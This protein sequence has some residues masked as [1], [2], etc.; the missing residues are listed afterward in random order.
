MELVFLLVWKARQ[1][2]EFQK[3][4][5]TLQGLLSQKGASSKEI[6][7]AFEALK[8]A[9]FPYEKNQTKEENRQMRE[10]LE[11]EVKRGPV[12]V[13]PLPELTRPKKSL[14]QEQQL[15]R[16]RKAGMKP[17]SSGDPFGHSARRS[18]KR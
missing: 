11:R 12:Q 5:S 17:I 4:R 14:R 8:E 7:E 13:T 3:S 1:N 6:L 10:M 18:Q 15:D 16:L 2:S 9:Y